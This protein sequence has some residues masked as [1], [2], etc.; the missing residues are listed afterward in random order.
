MHEGDE[1]NA[2]VHFLDAE[3]L[4]GEHGGD[5]D[6]FPVQADAPAG[7]PVA[8]GPALLTSIEGQKDTGSGQEQDR[9]FEPLIESQDWMFGGRELLVSHGV[10]GND[11]TG[12]QPKPEPKAPA[13]K[14][15]SYSGIMVLLHP[16]GRGSSL[17]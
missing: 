8:N 6:L 11:R 10:G 17:R 13:S 4:P 1:P 2:L 15:L 3:L 14:T 12:S 7:F 16:N 9:P 5:A